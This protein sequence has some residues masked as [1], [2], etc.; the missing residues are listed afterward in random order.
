[1]TRTH[2]LPSAPGT[3]RAVS[4]SRCHPGRTA[5]DRPAPHRRGAAAGRTHGS[6]R[7]GP[8]VT[9]RRGGVG[10]PVTKGEFVTAAG[11]KASVAKAG[12]AQREPLTSDRWFLTQIKPF[13][14]SAARRGP[15]L[16]HSCLSWPLGG[17]RAPQHGLTAAPL[18][19][20]RV[21]G[22]S[23]TPRAHCAGARSPRSLVVASPRCHGYRN[24]EVPRA[25]RRGLRSA[26]LWPRRGSW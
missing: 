22:R 4:P 20:G 14:L 9:W 17:T 15:A 13:R 26:L 2:R 16:R 1:M 10:L 23:L 21:R 7:G 3:N 6:W 24:P 18:S 8:G 5:A 11:R 25:G 19:P 12:Q